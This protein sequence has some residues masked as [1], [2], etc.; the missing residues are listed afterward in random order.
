MC[1]GRSWFLCDTSIV[2]QI[3]FDPKATCRVL[4]FCGRSSRAAHSWSAANSNS[5]FA[6]QIGQTGPTERTAVQVWLPCFDH[7]MT[8]LL[9]KVQ[10]LRAAARSQWSEFCWAFQSP[11]GEIWPGLRIPTMCELGPYSCTDSSARA[12]IT[13]RRL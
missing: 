8:L 3:V 12:Q 10:Q 6:A 5:E 2:L 4:R 13:G 11:I 9:Y 7:E 1:R